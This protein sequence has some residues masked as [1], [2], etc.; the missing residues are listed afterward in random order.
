[1]TKKTQQEKGKLR[2]GFEKK[3]KKKT[4]KREGANERDAVQVW[5]ENQ[6]GKQE[7]KKNSWGKKDK[8]KH[9]K[10]GNTQMLQIHDPSGTCRTTFYCTVAKAERTFF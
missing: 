8:I 9:R 3:K 1:M 5:R 6:A 2:K 7:G 10:L 4:L